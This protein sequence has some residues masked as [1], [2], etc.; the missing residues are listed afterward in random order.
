MAEVGDLYLL[1]GDNCLRTA[2]TP[3]TAHDLPT[4]AGVSL[5]LGPEGKE[6]VTGLYL[7]VEVEA[8]VVIGVG[9]GVGVWAGVE[10]PVEVEVEVEVGV[11]GVGGVG[12]GVGAKVEE[13]GD[14]LLEATLRTQA[15]PEVTLREVDPT[16]VLLF[17]ILP[18]I[19]VVRGNRLWLLIVV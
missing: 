5:A 8:E 10:V 17:H 3:G 12:V 9:V 2:E 14:L 11:G 18:L 15:I 13:E 4:H 7:E 19:A 1:T 6:S 16:L